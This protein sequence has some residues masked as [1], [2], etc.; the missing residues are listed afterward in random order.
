MMLGL[1]RTLQLLG[2]RLCLIHAVEVNFEGN[3]YFLI[4]SLTLLKR[5]CREFSINRWPH[6]K[7][8]SLHLLLQ[9][10]TLLDIN[11]V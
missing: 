4:P 9:N 6:R 1:R 10:L 11:I 2:R 3:V 7:I 8:K 5:R